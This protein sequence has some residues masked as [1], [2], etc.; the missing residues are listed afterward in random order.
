MRQVRIPFA[1]TAAFVLLLSLVGVP[2]S[3]QTPVDK[4]ANVT[5]VSRFEYTGGTE[6]GF[7]G[8][9]A[10]AGQFNGQFRR[11]EKA[12]QGGFKIFDL[13]GGEDGNTVVKVGE[14]NCAGT[15]NY[16][17]PLDPDLFGGRELVA[18]AHHSNTCNTAAQKGNGLMVVDVSDKANPVYIGGI[19]APSAHTLTLHPTKPVAYVQPGGLANGGGV[20]IVVDLA[21][22]EKPAEIGRFTS[23]QLGCHDLGFHVGPAG[24][25]AYC[26]GAGEV[27][28]WD[29]SDV[30]K[31]RTVGRIVNPAIQFPH[32]AVVSPNGKYVVINDEAFAAHECNTGTSVYGSLWI[33]DITDPDTPVLAG[34]IAPPKTEPTT[35]NSFGIGT[36]PGWVQS[37]C[38][39]H[40]Y[41]FVPG[42]NLLVS[43]WFSGGTRVHDIT[44]PLLP[45]EIAH[46]R[47]SDGVAYTA[48]YFDGRVVTNDMTRG[49]EVLDIPELRA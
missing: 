38:A 13:R 42:T 32:N 31:P 5:P 45:K 37:W 35:T 14:L 18:V 8:R 1:A 44:N 20:T 39:A 49:F 12:T 4:S 19:K 15:D 3:A 11:G 26:A 10:Y 9:Y 36:F 25:F 46:Y 48:H 16:A 33:Y 2:A 28:V 30:A 29:V 41:N 47:P 24:E 21:I 22:P 17:M 7:D 43:S 27:Q 34:R 40:N 6:I 23:S